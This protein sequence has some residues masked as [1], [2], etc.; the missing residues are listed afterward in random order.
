MELPW[1]ERINPRALDL[2]GQDLLIE[3]AQSFAQ[4]DW[5]VADS[6]FVGCYLSCLASVIGEQFETP[7]V[8]DCKIGNSIG[9]Y[10]TVAPISEEFF[11]ESRKAPTF[12]R[13]RIPFPHKLDL[14]SVSMDE[15]IYFRKRYADERRNLR[16]ALEELLEAVPE[17]DDPLNL[18]DHLRA[19]QARLEKAID[20]HQSA[21]NCF[22]L[23]AVP[24]VLQI[25]VRTGGIAWAK[26]A[27]LPQHYLHLLG[28]GMV[29]SLAFA[30]W[31]QMQDAHFAFR[32]NPYQ[33][34]LNMQNYL[35]GQW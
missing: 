14:Y 12:L 17:I 25:T 28:A 3:K 2:E 22:H 16:E 35:T 1:H 30:W 5:R 10:F 4:E 34:I 29:A 27:G 15:I 6:C 11:H 21:A 19:K 24:A 8:T 32:G 26:M 7:M 33:Y 20:D 31:S 13:L 9:E 23:R 18:I